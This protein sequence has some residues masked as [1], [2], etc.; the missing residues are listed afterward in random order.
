MRRGK[1]IG[2]LAILAA[3]V[4]AVILS[5][6]LFALLD[7]LQQLLILRD[8]W[9]FAEPQAYGEKIMAYG[10]TATLTVLMMALIYRLLGT[11]S[12][13]DYY[14]AVKFAF[15]HRTVA[16]AIMILMLITAFMDLAS[17]SEDRVMRYSLIHPR[18]I[19]YDLEQI[20]SVETGFNKDGFYY[21]IIVD[22]H[23]L[24][25]GTP[26]INTGRYP[27]YTASD[28]SEFADLDAKLMGVGIHK[29]ADVDSL[30]KADYN[31]DC[32]MNFRKIIK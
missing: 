28:Y 7:G 23:T 22:G 30:E 21:N 3:C 19:S 26:D 25:F 14:R 31:E 10:V 20:K 29:N 13:E 17:V 32:M 24:K 1:V 4:A 12:T 2:C 6:I 5:M 27:E 9:I 18:G 16:A 11:E 8:N 15:R